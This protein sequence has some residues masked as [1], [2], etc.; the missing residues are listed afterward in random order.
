[1]HAGDIIEGDF[2][3]SDYKQIIITLKVIALN[4]LLCITLIVSLEVY[5]KG[6]SLRHEH[7]LHI[8]LHFIADRSQIKIDKS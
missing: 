5:L 8:V 2:H 6:I 7:Y 1:M 4:R 3:R